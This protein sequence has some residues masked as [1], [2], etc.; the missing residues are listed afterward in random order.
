MHMPGKIKNNTITHIWIRII[1]CLSHKYIHEFYSFFLFYLFYFILF[2][3]YTHEFTLF[4]WG[5]FFL[6]VYSYYTLR[7]LHNINSPRNYYI[8]IYIYRG[9]V[10]Q[11]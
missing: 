11:N 4:Y 5:F 9:L 10:A 6:I 7:L 1:P 2:F 8:Y 3:G